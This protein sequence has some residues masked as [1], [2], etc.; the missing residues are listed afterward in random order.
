MPFERHDGGPLEELR[1]A[2]HPIDGDRFELREGF[3]YV[4]PD[5]GHRFPVPASADSTERWSTDL[6][7]VPHPLWSLIASYGRQSA[8]AVLHDHRSLVAER[9]ALDDP[10]AALAQRRADDRVF[11]TALREQR[12]PALRAWLMWAWVS[13]DRERTFR[14]VLGTVF[15][16]QSVVAGVALLVAVGGAWWHPAWLL[17]GLGALVAA[18]AWGR[19]AGL[20]LA[21]TVGGAVLAPIVAVHV[22]P[23]VV[24][25]VLEAVVELVSGGDPRAVVRP[26]VAG[27]RRGRR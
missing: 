6:A 14:G 11:R 10:A 22:V 20:Q 17:L 25:R 23:L 21:L 7:S 26:T 27:A 2:Q 13:A 5:S 18:L 16:I 24:F 12:V 9:R 3:V 8:P 4:D 19:L 15:V 1:L